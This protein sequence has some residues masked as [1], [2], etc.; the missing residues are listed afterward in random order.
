MKKY[1]LSVLFCLLFTS[2]SFAQDCVGGN[3]GRRIFTGRRVVRVFSFPRLQKG[4]TRLPRRNREF[5]LFPLF[6]KLW[7]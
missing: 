4:L 5:R 1:I 3:C 7:K 2:I 6:P